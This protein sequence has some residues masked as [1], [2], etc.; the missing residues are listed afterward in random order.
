[1]GYLELLESVSNRIQKEESLVDKLI[2]EDLLPTISLNEFRKRKISALVY[3]EYLQDEI[4]FCSEDEIANQIKNDDPNAVT[5]TVSELIE[6]E[7]LK[8]DIKALKN[9]HQTKKCFKNSTVV[10]TNKKKY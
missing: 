9:I 7:K 5:Y 8:P 2:T 3:S 1:M 10:A 4:W 6:I